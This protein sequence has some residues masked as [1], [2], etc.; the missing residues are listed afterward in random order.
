[1]SQQKATGVQ[2]N[3]LQKMGKSLPEFSIQRHVF[4]YMLSGVLLL[5]GLISYD[6]IGVDRFPKIEFPII[7]VQTILPGAS[8]EIVDSS[9]ANLIETTVNSVPG[10]EYIQSTSAPG[11]SLVVIRFGMDKNQDIAFNEVQ[12]QRRESGEI[13]GRETDGLG[14]SAKYTQAL[15]RFLKELTRIRENGWQEVSQEKAVAD[16]EAILDLIR[17]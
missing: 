3:A 4:A 9:V 10:I 8:P 2:D 7:S 16:I 6:R 11:I 13:K 14:L 15:G 1:M 5:F 12:A 17:D